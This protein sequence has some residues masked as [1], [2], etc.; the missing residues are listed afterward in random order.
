MQFKRK[1]AEYQQRDF[2]FKVKE[3]A[4]TGRFSGYASVFGVLDMYREVVAPGAFAKSLGEIKA[5]GRPLPALWQ[6]MSS[7][8][9]GG[10][11][12]LAEDANG[13]YVEGFL[14][15]EAVLQAR[16]AHALMKANVVSGLS[17]GYY[18]LGDSYNEKERVRTLTELD[19]VEVSIVTF[20]A[21]GEARIDEVKSKLAHGRLPTIRE[22]ETLLREQGF[23]KSKAAII[24]TRG[25]KHLLDSGEPSGANEA[26]QTLKA[27]ELPTFAE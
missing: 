4:D 12:A 23:S 20:P 14:L 27:F 3:V 26:I 24:A 7:N 5:S 16:E 15:T 11:D 17:I 19:L 10:Y 22:F 13:L 1:D 9:V 25:L 2:S 8:P 6:H 18:V 21:N